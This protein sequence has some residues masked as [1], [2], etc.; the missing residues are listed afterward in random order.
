MR[1]FGLARL[2]H[3][4]IPRQITMRLLRFQIDCRWL[5][6]DRSRIGIVNL[7]GFQIVSPKAMNR[8][9]EQ[10]WFIESIVSDIERECDRVTANRQ[11]VTGRVIKIIDELL[12]LRTEHSESRSNTVSAGQD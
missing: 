3:N 8:L 4:P 12:K 2:W 9:N 5:T 1:L 11:F 7:F 6:P 10:R